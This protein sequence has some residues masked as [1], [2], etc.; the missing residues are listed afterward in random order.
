MILIVCKDCGVGL[1]VSGEHAEVDSL[2]GER[3]DWYPDKYP[4]PGCG[5]SEAE[6]VDAIEPSAFNA[7]DLYD[8]SLQETFAALNGLGLPHEQDCGP[9]AVQNLLVRQQIA[10]VD[11]HLIKGTNRTVVYSLTFEDGT[12][13]YLGSSPYGATVYRI[14]KK[15]SFTKEALREA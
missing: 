15:R 12:T 2:I 6:M 5:K 8:L 7:L 3:S 4:C 11:C 10:K 1:R 13:L 9:T 14:A